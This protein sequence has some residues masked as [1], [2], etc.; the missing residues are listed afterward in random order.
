MA[1][2]GVVN[3]ELYHGM[4][5]DRCPRCQHMAEFDLRIHQRVFVLGLPFF[6]AGRST[7]VTCNN[8]NQE[9]DIHTAPQYI[10]D[11][12]NEEMPKLKT[13]VWAFSMAII[14]G[15]LMVVA[16]VVIPMQQ[17]K[18]K[19]YI[20]HPKE[21]D[22]YTIKY[23]DEDAIFDKERYTV[24]KVVAFSDDDITFVSSLYEA[25]G[26]SKVNDL[27]RKPD[28]ELWLYESE[29]YTKQELEE[30]IS[31]TADIH[32]HDIDREGD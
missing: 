2:I 23:D 3:R 17:K 22:I 31:I 4:V 32:I 16:M 6:P 21:G 10:R 1:Y 15:I 18:H 8:C 20:A 26:L 11:R 28:D 13:P 19:E 7:T 29:T 24:M 12:Y 9:V 30:W 25:T 27:L 5:A 14:L